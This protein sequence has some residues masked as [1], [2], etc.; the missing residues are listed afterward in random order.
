MRKHFVISVGCE[1][2]CYG[3]EIGKMI[4]KDFGIAYYDRKLVDDIMEEAGFSKDLAEKA[5][6]GVDIRGK[7]TK[8]SVAAGAPTQ[9]TNLTKR[10]VYIQ[11]EVIKKLAAKGSCVFIGR[12]SDYILREQD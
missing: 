6:A 9:Y 3:N 8:S 5:E 7:A 11:T 12:C 4:A 1:Y 10:M 2:G